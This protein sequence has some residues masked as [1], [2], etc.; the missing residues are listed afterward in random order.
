[1]REH[2][3]Y[4]FHRLF[5]LSQ[6][7]L[8]THNPT[9]LSFSTLQQRPTPPDS[10]SHGVAASGHGA[11]REGSSETTLTAPPAEMKMSSE[12]MSR[13]PSVDYTRYGIYA[14]SGGFPIHS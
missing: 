3:S 10:A 9:I 7:D 4:K 5:P 8:P 2:L 14:L 6:Y 12:Q 13:N 11:A 1:M